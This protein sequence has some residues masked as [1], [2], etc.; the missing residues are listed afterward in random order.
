[1]GISTKE[2]L[3]LPEINIKITKKNI[4]LNIIMSFVTNVIEMEWVISK[5]NINTDTSIRKNRY[6]TASS[7]QL[8][9]SSHKKKNKDKLIFSF[10]K[11]KIHRV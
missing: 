6:K 2:A 4:F 8:S 7:T 1:M 10:F 9:T 5:K 11:N 3:R